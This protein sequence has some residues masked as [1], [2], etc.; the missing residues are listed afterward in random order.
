M[1]CTQ[2]WKEPVIVCEDTNKK[3]KFPITRKSYLLYILLSCFKPHEMDFLIELMIPFLDVQ[4]SF[5]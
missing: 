4:M 3:K 1:S 5:T 2:N